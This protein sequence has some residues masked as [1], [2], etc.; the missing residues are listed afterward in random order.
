M[1]RMDDRIESAVLELGC[2]EVDT[3][4]KI[5]TKDGMTYTY[6]TNHRY[7]EDPEDHSESDREY[8]Q[9]V[10]TEAV[11]DLLRLNELIEGNKTILLV[12][13]MVLLNPDDIG[14]AWIE[15]GAIYEE[16]QPRPSVDDHYGKVE[17]V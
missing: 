6:E 5:R 9:R 7:R 17:L 13:E 1:K 15:L 12:E 10:Q 16:R 4:L 2:Q 8:I 11:E 14:R 3:L